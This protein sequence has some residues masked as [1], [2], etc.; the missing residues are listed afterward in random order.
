[1]VQSIT[2]F[3][4]PFGKKTKLGGKF[5]ASEIKP[6]FCLLGKSTEAPDVCL[7]QIPNQHLGATYS[8]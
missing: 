6:V 8:D 3:G 5:S 1:M 4:G 7:V 2:P